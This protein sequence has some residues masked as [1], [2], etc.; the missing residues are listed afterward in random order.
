MQAEDY[1]RLFPIS[2][3]S[4]KTGTQLK[5]GVVALQINIKG[6]KFTNSKG[7][8][9]PLIV[10]HTLPKKDLLAYT[11]EKP[12]V[13]TTNK[14]NQPLPLGCRVA[15]G[16]SPSKGQRDAWEKKRRKDCKK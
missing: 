12:L 7:K 4:G 13:I 14:S 6:V 1:E 15:I 16:G 5:S 11:K 3:G 9:V 2:D 8:N 10:N